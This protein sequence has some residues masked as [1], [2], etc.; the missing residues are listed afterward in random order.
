MKIHVIPILGITLLLAL[1]SC[2]CAKG[3][4]QFCAS[5]EDE[6]HYRLLMVNEPE[7]LPDVSTKTAADSVYCDAAF[8]VHSLWPS[9]EGDKRTNFSRFNYDLG[10]PADLNSKCQESSLSTGSALKKN[11]APRLEWNL[12]SID[13]SLYQRDSAEKFLSKFYNKTFTGYW[14]ADLACICPHFEMGHQSRTIKAKLIGKCKPDFKKESRVI[15]PDYRPEKT[16]R[17]NDINED[18]EC[19]CGKS[20]EEPLPKLNNPDWIPC[21]GTDW[22]GGCKIETYVSAKVLPMH[23]KADAIDEALE[24]FKINGKFYL[25]FATNIPTIS[26][27]SDWDAPYCN[28][29]S[30]RCKNDYKNPP[31]RLTTPFYNCKNFNLKEGGCE[32]LAHGIDI[33]VGEDLQYEGWKRDGMF[34]FFK[35]KNTKNLEDFLENFFDYSTQSLKDRYQEILPEGITTRDIM[36]MG[37]KAATMAPGMIFFDELNKQ[38]YHKFDKPRFKNLKEAMQYCKQKHVKA[39]K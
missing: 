2:A 1:I 26:Y 30:T 4:I 6:N 10:N 8:W 34:Y 9:F 35:Q 36:Q 21:Y 11:E 25:N 3:S 23:G 32:A 22:N 16:A 12:S 33:I 19:D 7:T 27:N 28:T 39:L 14:M 5:F 20:C 37:D 15:P 17:N 38:G 13:A 24:C 18:E 31:P 29:D